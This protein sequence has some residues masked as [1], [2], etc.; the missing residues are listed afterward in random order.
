VTTPL[1]AVEV[2]TRKNLP[3]WLT[4]AVE[5]AV[6][7]AEPQ[8]VPIVVFNEA[9]QGRRTRRYVVVRMEDWVELY[10]NEKEAWG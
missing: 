1:F 8:Q 3:G 6:R 9:S 2:K 5:Q 4:A 7:A 10:G